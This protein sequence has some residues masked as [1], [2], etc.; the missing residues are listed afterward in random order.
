M[1]R[2]HSVRHTTLCV[3]SGFVMALA[4][5]AVTAAESRDKGLA[6][7]G[8]DVR[9]SEP[10]STIHWS[11]DKNGNVLLSDRP[12]PAAVE[13]G[14]QKFNSTSDAASL[15]RAK[16]EREYWRSQAEA[17]AARQRDREREVEES[18]RVRL[19]AQRERDRFYG[20]YGYYVLPGVRRA[21]LAMGL[22]F[23]AAR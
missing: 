17:F 22:P 15:A 9:L 4:T 8:A 10:T 12:D 1:A 3:I 6:L 14:V 13:Q 7:N 5:G 20:D 16:M 19:L 2:I 23:S 21:P 18:R 11:V